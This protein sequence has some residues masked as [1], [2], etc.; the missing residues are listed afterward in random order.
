MS[1]LTPTLTAL[2][3]ATGAAHGALDRSL[4]LAHEPSRRDV[5]LY[6][7]AMEGFL[8]P[9]EAEL[10]AHERLAH[11]EPE[12]RARKAAWLRTDLEALGCAAH[13]PRAPL[14]PAVGRFPD[15]LG[16]AYVVEGSTL[17]GRVL[18]RRPGLRGLRFFEGYGEATG[19]L[20][21]ELVA[22]VERV[23]AEPSDRSAILRAAVDT[24][25]RVTHWLERHGALRAPEDTLTEVA[26]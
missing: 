4:R 16:V 5:V 18:A 3:H 8:E 7:R 17:G 26:S 14:P 10:W 21:R 19:R 9:L 25:E 13:G 12:R 1:A 15:C 11:L 20:W 24:F 2:R 22:E 23:G 6:L